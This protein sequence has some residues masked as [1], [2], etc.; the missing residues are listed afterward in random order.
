MLLIFYLTSNI[1]FLLWGCALAFLSLSMYSTLLDKPS[2]ILF[3][4]FL[5][6]STAELIVSWIDTGKEKNT[7][8]ENTGD[9]A[10]YSNY[11][12]ITDTGKTA[13]PGTYPRKKLTLDGEVIYE[14]VYSIGDD[15]FRLTKNETLDNSHRINFFGCSFTFGAGLNDDETLPHYVKKLLPDISVKNYGFHGYGIHEAL[16]ILQSKLDTSGDINFLLTSPWH[17]LRSACVQKWTRGSPKYELAKNGQVIRNGRCNTKQ[18]SGRVMEALSKSALAGLIHDNLQLLPSTQDAQIELYLA[19]IREMS[20]LSRQR[21]Q[22][23]IIGYIQAADNWFKGDY[24]NEHIYN[25]L[26]AMSD[27]IV[28]MSLTVPGVKLAKHYYIHKLDT[29]PTAEANRARAGILAEVLREHL[30]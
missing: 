29:H 15:G 12:Q 18:Y 4:T 6:L 10:E 21:N 16:A 25:E 20:E 14:V 26:S 17:S 22:K 27:E 11:I 28:D 9:Y 1:H 8:Y 2:V 5:A 24:T 30:Y 13:R 3:G 23:F 7:Y 19:L